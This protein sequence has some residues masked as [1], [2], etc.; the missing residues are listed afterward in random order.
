MAKERHES[1]EFLSKM[2]ISLMN[3]DKLYNY[4]FLQAEL[5]MSKR[6]VSAIKKGHDMFIYQYVRVV[7]YITEQIHLDILMDVLLKQLKIMLAT[8]SDLVIGIVPHK[9]NRDSR[10]EEWVVVMRWDGAYV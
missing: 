3:V 1:Y 7:N 6:D 4:P 2:M 10:P 8:H 5:H 9:N